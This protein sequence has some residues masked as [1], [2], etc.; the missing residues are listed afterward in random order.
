MSIRLSFDTRSLR[1]QNPNINI[2]DFTVDLDDTIYLPV[3]DERKWYVSLENLRI[4]NSAFNVTNE[5]DNRTISYKDVISGTWKVITLPEG[6]YGWK[7]FQ[8][9]FRREVQANGDSTVLN[10][11]RKYGFDL[12]IDLSTLS[13]VFVFETINSTNYEVRVDSNLNKNL[14][15]AADAIVRYDDDFDTRRGAGT[16]PDIS[17]GITDRATI[18]CSLV[19]GSYSNGSRARGLYN[20]AFDVA[21]GTLLNRSPVNLA[22]LPCVFSGD[23]FRSFQIT[24]VGGNSRILDLQDEDW[25]ADILLERLDK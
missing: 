8:N 20:F 4:F 6:I 25:S 23:S 22:Y 21:P 15:F 14:G 7:E 17:L 9:A 10:G 2:S 24:L 12:R 13:F 3:R 1:K 11:E 5:L 19:S 18:Q 16:K